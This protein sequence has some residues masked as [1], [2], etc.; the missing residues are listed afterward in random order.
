[1]DAAGLD[2]LGVLDA[3]GLD[4]LGVLDA[5]GLDGLGVLDAAGLDGLGFLDAAGLDGLGVL[6]AALAFAACFSNSRFFLS[7][8][9]CSL[10]VVSLLTKPLALFTASFASLLNPFGDPFGEG[11]VT[12]ALATF[13]FKSVGLGVLDAGLDGLGVLVAP[14][15]DAAGL[16]GLGVLDEDG[17]DGLGFL[18]EDGL[19]GLG[20]LVAAL[21][22]AACFSNS[23]FFLSASI[24]SLGV[25]SLLT[26]PLALFT[27]SFASLLNPFGDPFGEGDVTIAL[28]TFLFKSVGL[29]D[30]D[31]GLEGLGVLDAASL[32]GVGDLN[33]GLEGLG[34][35]DE[36]GLEGL[37]D[38]V[39]AWALTTCLF[40]LRSSLSTLICSLGVVSRF[41]KPLALFTASFVS[42]LNPLG[43][44]LGDGD[45]TIASFTFASNSFPLRGDSF[46]FL[47]E[48]FGVPFLDI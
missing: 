42:L 30:L 3:A 25:V 20:V 22:F 31:D 35:L 36:D 19:E 39:A 6:D 47:G 38:L 4:G 21:A 17:L 45:V 10:G 44:S 12:I 26:K 48:I 15:L 24:C 23:R 28:A 43:D 33:D 2:G 11:D 32:E 16:E 34:V 37:C 40:N 9:I 41:S 7:A 8:S 27:A 18:D 29:G 13:L 46:C 5:A 14:G 1:M